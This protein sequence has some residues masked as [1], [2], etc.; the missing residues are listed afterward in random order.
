[1]WLYCTSGDTDKPIVLYEYQ[2]GRGAKPPKEFLTGFKGY[3]HTDSYAGHHNLP[4]EI[5]VVAA[6]L[7]PGGNLTR[8]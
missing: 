5:T 1:M 8:Q 6:G 4:E 2:P 7:T 3:L